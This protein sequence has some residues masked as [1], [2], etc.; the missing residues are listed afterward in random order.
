MVGKTACIAFTPRENR[1]VF[2][3]LSGEVFELVKIS[4][5]NTNGEQPIK[6]NKPKFVYIPQIHP[7]NFMCLHI[8]NKI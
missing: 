7:I 4:F 3:L 1:G 5:L 8:N 6:P 2:F